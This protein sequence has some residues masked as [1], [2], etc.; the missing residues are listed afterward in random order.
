[1]NQPPDASEPAATGDAGGAGFIHPS[2]TAG[3]LIELKEARVAP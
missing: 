1:M 3:V 2:A